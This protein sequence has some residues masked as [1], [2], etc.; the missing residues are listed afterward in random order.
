[1]LLLL[2]LLDLCCSM[3]SCSSLRSFQT[4]CYTLLLQPDHLLRPSLSVL[5][6]SLS[7]LRHSGS[8]CRNVKG[9]R[10]AG[11]AVQ[12]PR[13]KDGLLDMVEKMSGSACE[14]KQVRQAR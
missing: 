2:Q 4:Y 3:L 11:G 14:I 5:R 12:F 13:R 10:G 7:V 6:P 8:W 1:M 9:W